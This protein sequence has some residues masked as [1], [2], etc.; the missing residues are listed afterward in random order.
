MFNY[1]KRLF[2]PVHVERQDPAFA[3]V[4]LE[5]YAGKDSELSSALQY[6]NQR[7]NISNR[8]I[9]ELLGIIAA[10]ELGHMELISVAISKLGGLPLTLNNIQVPA[11]KLDL[12]K[13]LDVMTMLQMD[14]KAESR[15]GRLYRKHMEL[16]NDVYMKK[17]LKFLIERGEVHKYLLKKAQKLIKKN[18]SQ[19]EFNELIYDYKMSLQVLK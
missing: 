10:E 16:T 19:E 5:H 2:Y 13:N 18:G 12:D 8:P 17:L 9:R 6:F 1:H 11:E 3:K 4:L 7:S 15:V 14:I